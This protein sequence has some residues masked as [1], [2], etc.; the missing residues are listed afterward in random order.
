[1]PRPREAAGAVPKLRE[2][3]FPEA[4]DK[5]VAGGLKPGT[6]AAYR[7]AYLC[8]L[9]RLQ[10]TGLVGRCTT[11]QQLEGERAVVRQRLVVANHHP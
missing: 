6:L 7:L 11:E 4:E 2:L 3:E 9:N 1:V 10:K 8:L 5:R